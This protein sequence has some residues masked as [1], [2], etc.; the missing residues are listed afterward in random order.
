MLVACWMVVLEL[1]PLRFL[2]MEISSVLLIVCCSFG[3]WI[4]LGS[5]RL[6]VMLMRVWFLLVVFGIWI[7]WVTKL[8][9]R[10]RIMGGGG[11]LF[12]S[13]MLDVVWWGFVI[14]GILLFVIFI[15]F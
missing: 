2:R 6:K 11:F 1:G 7:A 5:L 8:L 13:L 14:G 9:M 4:R 15:V 3:V 12:M 10:L